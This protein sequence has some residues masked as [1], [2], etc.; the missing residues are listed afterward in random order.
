MQIVDESNC[1]KEP[2]AYIN[3]IQSYGAM[4]VLDSAMYVA[5][6]SSNI[7][8]WL[9]ETTDS[10]IGEHCSAFF[11]DR[12][13]ETLNAFALNKDR[14]LVPVGVVG[15]KVK[16]NAIAHFSDGCTIIELEPRDESTDIHD[17]DNAASGLQ[18]CIVTLSKTNTIEEFADELVRCV[19][20]VTGLDRVM[21][22]KFHEDWHGEVIGEARAP[23]VDSY[24]GNHFPASDIPEPAR[25]LFMANWTR[26]IADVISQPISLVPNLVAGRGRPINLTQSSLR[27]PSPIHVEYLKNMN[28]GAS[29]TISLIVNGRLWGLIAGHHS[30]AKYT[31]YWIRSVCEFIGK[32]ASEHLSG[33][34][35]KEALQ[36]VSQF[37]SIGQKILESKNRI[38]IFDSISERA[39]RLFAA[40]GVLYVTDDGQI[41]GKCGDEIA[42]AATISRLVKVLIEEKRSSIYFTNRL[43]ATFELF[44]GLQEKASGLIAIK[45]LHGY[46]LI[47]RPEYKH[48]LTWGGN[49]EKAVT[50]SAPDKLHPRKSFDAWKEQVAGQSKRW[51]D[52]EVVAAETLASLLDASIPLYEVSENKGSELSEGLR[53]SIKHSI[54]L[55]DQLRN[56]ELVDPV[57]SLNLKV[58]QSRY[59]E[60]SNLISDEA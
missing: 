17:A 35:K 13:I 27:Q 32:F 3:E 25:K 2:V 7:S 23:G 53:V 36:L 34:I 55:L 14:A 9:G 19:R 6:A 39:L 49:P 18:E 12:Q 38:S 60:L 20:K 24:L 22:Y 42:P 33:I 29:L 56:E 8:D 45:M 21:L 28:V 11:S 41:E 57:F 15:S 54:K 16:A 40:S 44:R 4:L 58:L 37:S 26:L 5:Q 43:P 46:L 47:F 10:I 48:T 52:S 31:N 1:D 30:T 59:N 50:A 51:T